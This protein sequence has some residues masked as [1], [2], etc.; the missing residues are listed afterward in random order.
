MHQSC[1]V[2]SNTARVFDSGEFA[3]CKVICNGR[4]FNTHRLILSSRSEYFR[5]SLTG[6]WKVRRKVLSKVYISK[7]IM[8][9]GLQESHTG[10][11]KL[12]DHDP[13]K[14]E[15]LLRYIYH[16]DLKWH[17]AQAEHGGGGADFLPMLVELTTLGD[18]FLVQDLVDAAQEAIIDTC[19]SFSVGFWTFGRPVEPVV[20]WDDD[21]GHHSDEGTPSPF[22]LFASEFMRAISLTPK[23][24]GPTQRIHKFLLDFMVH[25]LGCLQGVSM[26]HSHKEGLATWFDEQL[27]IVSSLRRYIVGVPGLEEE[28]KT[29]LFDTVFSGAPRILPN[30]WIDFESDRADKCFVCRRPLFG[31]GMPRVVFN[32][33]QVDEGQIWCLHCADDASRTAW[34][35][36]MPKSEVHDSQVSQKEQT[37]EGP[38]C[39]VKVFKSK[40]TPNSDGGW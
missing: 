24:S 31:R 36:F 9:Y 25:G 5:K 29:V 14:I 23:T 22:D 10:E 27:G 3:D 35:R 1:Q 4:E 39:R 2:I 38:T 7:L 37:W 33:I 8:F 16:Q 13:E 12:D 32:P 6:P 40:G 17:R 20:I 34:S 26:L 11:V 28:V 15:W 30:P 19:S 21:E 18:Y